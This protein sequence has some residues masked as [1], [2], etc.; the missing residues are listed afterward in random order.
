MP[1]CSVV[2]HIPTSHKICSSVIYRCTHVPISH[3]A[4]ARCCNVSR[5]SYAAPRCT[6]FVVAA[7]LPFWNA[8]LRTARFLA[9]ARLSACNA[10]AHAKA[11]QTVHEM[12]WRA[13]CLVHEV[14]WRARCLST[15]DAFL[16]STQHLQIELF[17]D[18][19]GIDAKRF[20]GKESEA[21]LS[22]CHGRVC[23]V[24]VGR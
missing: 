22:T 10:E 7:V 21:A 18:D 3:K 8:A 15:V 2:N 23:R 19:F 4:R 1:D 17:R 5:A 12:L 13:R 16:G 9:P 24:C 14:L 11:Q 20:V 6:I